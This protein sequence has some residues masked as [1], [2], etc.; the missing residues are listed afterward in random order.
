MCL[1][2][3]N[4]NIDKWC[5]MTQSQ[6]TLGVKGLLIQI[7]KCNYSNIIILTRAWNTRLPYCSAL[8]FR[9]ANSASKMSWRNC[10]KILNTIFLN[11]K[12]NL[13]PSIFFFFQ[14]SCRKP[15]HS[16]SQFPRHQ[17]LAKKLILMGL[18]ASAISILTIQ[19]G[20]L[21]KISIESYWLVNKKVN[22][23]VL[24]SE[25]YILLNYP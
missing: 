11:I 3:D 5:L 21:Q 8:S 14:K 16:P 15:L 25:I 4:N 2:E 1:L 19:Q 22:K 17:F 13:D 18:D 6:L 7:N 12:R 23:H 9:I 24:N 10:Q 20:P